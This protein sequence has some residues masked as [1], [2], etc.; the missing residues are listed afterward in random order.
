PLPATVTIDA[1]NRLARVDIQAA[2]LSVVRSDLAGV[3]VR[4]ETVRNPTDTDV[5]IPALGFSLAGTITMP[6]QVAGRLRYPAIVLVPG[7]GPVDRDV[8]VYGIPIFAQLAGALA[9]RGFIVLR[10]D[11]RAVGQSGGRAE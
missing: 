11:K 9:E 10:Y 1:R 8:N 5:R 7:S 6:P 2:G 3:S 4:T